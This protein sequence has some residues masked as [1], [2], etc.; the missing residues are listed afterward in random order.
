LKQPA[1]AYRG[2]GPRPKILGV[3]SG[4]AL[5]CVALFWPLR[6][7][8]RQP[9]AQ[10]RGFSYHLFAAR[11]R[12]SSTF[13]LRVATRG[14][15]RLLRIAQSLRAGSPPGSAAR[16]MFFGDHYRRPE[17]LLHPVSSD[18]LE[19]ER[20]FLADFLLDLKANKW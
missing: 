8:A 12:R 1:E 18:N 4:I 13:A 19:F 14:P 5:H 7:A 6:F 17:G 10:G 15:V 11:K 20:A 3:I 9:A 2:F 16:G